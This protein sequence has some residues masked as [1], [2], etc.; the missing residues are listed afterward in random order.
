[1]KL[2]LVLLIG[3]LLLAGCAEPE[4]TAVK[5]DAVVEV[6]LLRNGVNISS[7]VEIKNFHQGANVDVIYRITNDTVND[8]QPSLYANLGID[9]A[10]YSSALDY[11]ATPLFVEDWLKIPGNLK[12]A[13]GETRSAVVSLTMPK[14]FNAELLPD[15]FTFRVGAASGQGGLF[16]TAV[17]NWWLVE[18]R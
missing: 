2:L 1:M 18:M 16:E 15:R 5:P 17:E 12:V 6:H 13:A 8:L 10:T 14:K 9:P 7:N 11:K 3:L 4:V